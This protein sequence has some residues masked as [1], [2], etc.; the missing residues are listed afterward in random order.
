MTILEA[1]L[2][3]ELAQTDEALLEWLIRQG[4]LLPY[5]R[6]LVLSDMARNTCPTP[7]QEEDELGDCGY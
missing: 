1:L 7:E 2:A 4:D 6:R 3:K 5:L